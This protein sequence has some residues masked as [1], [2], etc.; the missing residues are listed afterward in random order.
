MNK[1]K[2]MINFSVI[3]VLSF[4]I[5]VIAVTIQNENDLIENLSKNNNN[6]VNL[7]IDNDITVTKNITLSTTVNKL[8]L[9]GTSLSTSKLIF[10]YPIYFD[11]N[12]EKIEL[13]NI[14]I[15]GTLLF[16]NNKHITLD[17]VILNGNIH[18]DMDDNANEYIKFN[19]LIYRPIKNTV[20]PHCI[21]IK[22]NLEI[23]DSEL[24]GS[25][26]CQQR[27]L[28]F[29]GLKNYQILIKNSYFSGE[30]QCPCLSITQSK[31][32]NIT[33]SIFEKGFSNKEMDGG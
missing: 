4:I 3:I 18:T 2:N 11:D 19:H 8:S 7:T 30:N 27:L 14:E 28:N 1:K 5:T 13:K 20:H 6:E 16:H 15:N 9:I 31:N 25:S 21:N 26:S 23:S 32:A 22:G 17:N 33:Y 29:D 24:Y 12:V 10:N